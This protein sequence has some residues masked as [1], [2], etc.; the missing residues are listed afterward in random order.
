LN[1]KLLVAAFAALLGGSLVAQQIQVSRSGWS[2]TPGSSLLSTNFFVN[3]TTAS[4]YIAGGLVVQVGTSE[5]GSYVYSSTSWTG[6]TVSGPQFSGGAGPLTA[7]AT[8][9]YA[10][11]NGTG[12]V[13]ANLAAQCNQQSFVYLQG[14]GYRA[15][16]NASVSVSCPTFGPLQAVCKA[17]AF[18]GQVPLTMTFLQSGSANLTGQN[19]WWVAMSASGDCNG[20]MSGTNGLAQLN[21]ICEASGT[22]ILN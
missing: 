4:D 17:R 2:V 18:P 20:S 16:A 13:Q 7:T 11:T 5:T 12:G 1:T 8:E 21:A 9:S 10:R 15:A 14:S 22:I 3:G 19:S 6:N